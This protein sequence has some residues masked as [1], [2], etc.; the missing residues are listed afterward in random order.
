MKTISIFANI[1]IFILST[2]FSTAQSEDPSQENT[3]NV[4]T[5]WCFGGALPTITFDSDLGFQ[6]GALVNIYNYGDGS[7]YPRYDHSLYFE[8]SRFTPSKSGINRFFYDS[9]RLL[10]GIRTTFDISYLTDPKM[11]FFGFNGYESTYNSTWTDDEDP[12]YVSRVFYGYDRKMFRLKGD[13]HGSLLGDNLMWVTGFAFYNFDA[14]PVDI[15]KLNKNKSDDKKV[16]DVEVLYDN[17]VNWGIIAQDEKDGGWANYL[18][19]GVAYDSRDNEPNPM[20]GLWTE[21]VIQMAPSFL[22]NG[23]FGHT[24][25]AITHRQYFTIVKN[26]LSFAYRIAYQGT[27]GGNVPFYAQPLVITSFLRGATSQGLG[28]SKTLRG[29]IRH[30]VVGDGFVYGN[31]EL[32]WKFTGFTFLKSNNIYLALNTFLDAGT[33][34]SPINVNKSNVVLY[35]GEELSDYFDEEKDSIHPSV[36]AGLRVVMNENFIIAFDSG[37][38][39]DPRDGNIGI[40]IGL[41][42]LF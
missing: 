15:E 17:Y 9:D 34:V 13:F 21:A 12:E 42:Y 8:Y 11:D 28:G 18:K 6:Y 22:G 31:F 36:G 20:K 7:R 40:Y 24:K 32:R 29:I 35:A 1:F 37:K 39:L 25:I 30:R 38:A 41:N 5:G 26:D 16:P 33:V 3:A 19:L 10:K 27:L 4:K 14:G 2:L 23:D